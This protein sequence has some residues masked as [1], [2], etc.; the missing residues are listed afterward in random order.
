MSYLAS[1][2]RTTSRPLNHKKT[3]GCLQ[4]LFILLS[5]AFGCIGLWTSLYLPDTFGGYDH[6]SSGVENMLSTYTT[7]SIYGLKDETK[8]SVLGNN[9]S[10]SF[11]FVMSEFA[12]RVLSRHITSSNILVV[13]P[14]AIL[15]AK[16]DSKKNENSRHQNSVGEAFLQYSISEGHAIHAIESESKGGTRKSGPTLDSW[17]KSFDE[18][19]RI[20]DTSRGWWSSKPL[21]KPNWILLAVFDLAFGS[22]DSVWKEA[23]TFLEDCTVTYF[24]VAIH[25]MKRIDGSYEIGGMKAMESLLRKKYKVQVLSSSH[26][27]ADVSNEREIFERYGPNALFQSAEEI[28]NYLRWGADAAQQHEESKD[29]VFTS[30][31]FATQGLDLAIPTPQHYL[32]Q[33]GTTIDV[34]DEVS[35]R[36]L[37]ALKSCPK[38]HRENINFVFSEVSSM[39]GFIDFERLWVRCTYLLLLV[40]NTVV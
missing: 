14:G 31:I 9:S 2:K 20:N 39:L 33:P 30:Y 26:Y 5:C 18:D 3:I 1:S 21:E 11:G 16:E 6:H 40:G 8:L 34:F 27:H 4:S 7:N 10:T 36:H 32:R 29:T 15:T 13:A 23:K 17:W 24:V 22:E 25:S 28:T 19:K 35:M 12:C 37:P 38:A